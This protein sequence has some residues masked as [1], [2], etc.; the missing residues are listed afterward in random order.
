MLRQ[1]VFGV[2]VVQTQPFFCTIWLELFWT[3]DCPTRYN[4]CLYVGVQETG[5]GFT[6]RTSSN[7]YRTD[8]TW[9]FYHTKLT[10]L[11]SRTRSKRT[12]KSFLTRITRT[13]LRT[14]FRFC[15]QAS[16]R[17]LHVLRWRRI[18]SGSLV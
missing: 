12:S 8:S 18:P 9:S 14:R 3:K 6:R 15:F 5:T 1:L 10:G 13:F 7:T 4:Q 16:P 2:L 17:I 11:Q